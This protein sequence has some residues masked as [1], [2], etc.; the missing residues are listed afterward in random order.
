ME[1]LPLEILDVIVTQ[2][3]DNDPNA[4]LSLGM[5]CTAYYDR[6][7]V[8]CFEACEEE[9]NMLYEHVEETVVQCRPQDVIKYF[10]NFDTDKRRRDGIY[11]YDSDIECKAWP[12]PHLHY[13]RV[14]FTR[15]GRD[16]DTWECKLDE[17][18]WKVFG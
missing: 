15:F 9:Q 11:V 4:W 17:R 18:E 12:I 1:T 3:F 10:S 14:R 6:Y 2:L 7:I 5:S 8:P 16:V 13:A